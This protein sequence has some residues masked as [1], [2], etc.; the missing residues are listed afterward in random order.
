MDEQ[1]TELAKRMHDQAVEDIE[2]Q[3]TQGNSAY[4]ERM[5][6]RW[7][8]GLQ[9]SSDKGLYFER[10]AKTII[11]INDEKLMLMFGTACV[12]NLPDRDSQSQVAA[13][14]ER[15]LGEMVRTR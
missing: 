4:A 10:V 7:V 8:K 6:T 2:F 12:R 1:A 13:T 14:L 5:A 9:V 3:K 15:L 11:G